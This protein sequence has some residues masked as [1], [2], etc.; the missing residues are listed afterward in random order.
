MPHIPSFF[1]GVPVP[2]NAEPLVMRRRS[3]SGD[4]N[5]RLPTEEEKLEWFEGRQL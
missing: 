5:Y 4:W 3:P 1:F 2:F